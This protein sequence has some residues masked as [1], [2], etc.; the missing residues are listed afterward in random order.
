[1]KSAKVGL[2]TPERKILIILTY[3]VVL[4]VFSLTAFTINSINATNFIS[5]LFRYFACEESGYN[6]EMP[7]DRSQFTQFG[8]PGITAVAGIL[9]S[10]FPVVNLVYVVNITE[11]RKKW[12]ACTA[13]WRR[14]TANSSSSM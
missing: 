9:F 4:S 7:C 6:S 5:S 11:L 8:Y 13:A 3:Y 12:N 2:S 1:M 14:H 10:L